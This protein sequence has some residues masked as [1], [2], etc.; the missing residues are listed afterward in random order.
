MEYPPQPFHQHGFILPQRRAIAKP[1][2]FAALVLGLTFN[3]SLVSVMGSKLGFFSSSVGNA[4][5]AGS[6]LFLILLTW[7]RRQQVSFKSLPTAFKT[8]ILILCVV[9][10][11]LG[12]Y[13]VASPSVDRALK[14]SV[15]L[16]T[17][18]TVIS[19]VALTM[20]ARMFTFAEVSRGLLIFSIVELVGCILIF[21][22]NTDVNENAIAVRATVA[23]M[24]LYTLLPNKILGFAAVGGCL[25]FSVSLGCRT[26]AMAL[27]GAI[28]SLEVEKR[29]RN[30]RGVVVIASIIGFSFLVLFI[31]WLVVGLKSLATASLG[32]DNP[33]AQFFLHDKSADKISYD[34]FDRFDVWSYSWEHIREKPV[35]GYGIGTE[36]AIMQVRS[37]NAYL[38]LMFEGGIVLLVSWLWFYSR[39]T[40]GLFNPKWIAKVGESSL[41]RLSLL[42]IVYMSLAGMVESSGLSSVSTP[43]NLIFIFLSVWLFQPKKEHDNKRF[44]G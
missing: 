11:L 42:L 23:C 29:T 14:T 30:K 26:S 27:L 40:S 43:I 5:A 1:S 22:A 15:V 2:F 31:P 20:A 35:L 12:L 7:F 16:K 19:L 6:L 13:A 36:H 39:A 18:G 4:L 38:S 28:G 21:R 24:C 34:F 9:T 44:T 25:A 17:G 3:A 8:S 33:I 37:H 41:F 32:S 10:C